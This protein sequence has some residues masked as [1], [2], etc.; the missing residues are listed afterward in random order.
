MCFNNQL[1]EYELDIVND[2]LSFY[3]EEV[4]KNEDEVLY[5]YYSNSHI[6]L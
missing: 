6:T 2:P 1:N 5:E 4:E 3:D